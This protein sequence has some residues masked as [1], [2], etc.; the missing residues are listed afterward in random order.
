MEGTMAYQKKA[1][2]DKYVRLTGLWPSKNKEGLWTGRFRAED[3]EKLLE[4]ASEALDN[5]APL[6]FSLWENNE[7]EGKRDPDFSLQCF[8][9]DAEEKPS[10]GGRSWASKKASR[11]AEK[12]ED[13]EE[14]AEV[15]AEEDTDEV[16]PEEKPKKGV[17]SSTKKRSRW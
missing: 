5:G 15:E 17:K 13:A 6:V 14:D 1:S 4:K 10:S 7:K 11:P 2:N 16:E 3:M 12:E 8:V 9:G